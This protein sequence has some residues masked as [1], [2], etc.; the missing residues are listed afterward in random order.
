VLIRDMYFMEPDAPNPTRNYSL[1]DVI[2]DLIKD[3]DDPH[4]TDAR[5][6]AVWRDGRIL[7]VVR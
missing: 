1:R 7:A 3:F 4:G 2:D 5:D 6:L